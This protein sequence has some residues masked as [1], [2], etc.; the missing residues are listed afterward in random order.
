MPIDQVQTAVQTYLTANWHSTDV[1]FENDSFEP[2][3]DT[4]GTILPW[5]LVEIYGGLYEQRSMGAGSAAADFW[6]DSG[7]VWFHIIVGTGTGSLVAKQYA[8][9]LA[10]LFRGLQVAP[11]IAFGDIAIGAS[12]G[13]SDGNDWS[14]SVSVDWIQ[15]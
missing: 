6:S 8:A 7:T 11:N 15:G 12:G 1:A 10:E 3:S 9:A 5:M 13:T 14:L 4:N 2:R